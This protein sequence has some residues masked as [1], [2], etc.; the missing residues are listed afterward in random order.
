MKPERIKSVDIIRGFAVLWMVLFQT[1]DF[2]SKDFRL[3]GFIWND[4]LDFLNWFPIFI[5]VSGMSVWLMINKRLNSDHSKWTVLI[6]GLKRYT[7][8]IFLGLLLCLWCFNLEVFLSMNEILVAIGIYAI[9][10]LCI[11]LMVYDREVILIPI[12]FITYGLSYWFRNPLRFQYYPFYW[13][14]P[15]FFVG[16]LFAKLR[17]A[18]ERK[19]GAFLLLFFLISLA[20][21]TVVGDSFRYVDSSLG[22]AVFNATLVIIIL[23]VIEEEQN[24]KTLEVLGFM[25]RNAL[26]FYLFHYVVLYKVANG[27][28][29][30]Q[31]LDWPPT[32]LVTCS[33]IAL[34]CFLAYLQPRLAEYLKDRISILHDG[35]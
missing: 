24:A 9:V 26:L 1:T 22:F 33:S 14:L 7:F 25:G 16:A 12:I 23:P 8:Y 2:F 10:T 21:L 17:Y 31:S 19:E 30:F 6:Y 27:F 4:Y 5:F 29:V 28:D 34:I 15:L 32:I 11:L 20:A 3:Y 18:K 13:T 35:A